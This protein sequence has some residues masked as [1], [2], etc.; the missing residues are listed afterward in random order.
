MEILNISSIYTQQ[1]GCDET[2]KYKFWE[3]LNKML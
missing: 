2:S 3:D 1:T